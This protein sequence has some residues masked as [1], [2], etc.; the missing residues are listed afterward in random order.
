[1]LLKIN[2]QQQ[3]QQQQQQTHYILL[4]ILSQSLSNL[5]IQNLIPFTCKWAFYYAYVNCSLNMSE[6][7]ISL[8]DM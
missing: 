7:N 6:E 8:I 1:M 4:Q 2:E 5:L 3:Q